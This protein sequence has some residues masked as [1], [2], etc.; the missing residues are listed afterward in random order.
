MMAKDCCTSIIKK[1]YADIGVKHYFE[2]S[3][4]SHKDCFSYLSDFV[5]C[6]S[7]KKKTKIT[8][9]QKEDTDEED[10]EE[11]E[12]YNENGF[13][14]NGEKRL[15]GIIALKKH[16][17]QSNESM[18]IE[19]VWAHTTSSMVVGYISSSMDNPKSLV[20]RLSSSDQDND[21]KILE[22]SSTITTI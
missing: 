6:K 5:N 15:G 19:F 1:K 17:N 12:E 21:G 4:L 22:M 20:S 9:E 18:E 7:K 3:F 14:F 8:N 10:E 11:E 13:K 2:N 16:T